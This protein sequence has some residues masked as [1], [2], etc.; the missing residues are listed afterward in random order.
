MHSIGFY[1]EH[2][3]PD[4]DLFLIIHE[5]NIKRGGV[6]A[7]DHRPTVIDLYQSLSTTNSGME[8][9]FEKLSPDSTTD[10]DF[11]FDYNSVMQY[12]G[13]AFS[14]NGRPTVRC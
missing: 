11:D 2:Q 6:L 14:R 3:R 7:L 8:Y 4:R 9:E 10:L 13:T 1:H 5:E 12:E